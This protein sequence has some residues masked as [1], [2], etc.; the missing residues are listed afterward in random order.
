MSEINV[1][2]DVAIVNGSFFTLI[3]K[4]DFTPAQKQI[5]LTTYIDS[6]NPNDSNNFRQVIIKFFHGKTT[7]ATTHIAMYTCMY[8]TI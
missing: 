2:T 1:A 8:V 3:P 5:H 7:L 6:Y 4:N